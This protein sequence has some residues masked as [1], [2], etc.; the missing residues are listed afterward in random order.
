MSVGQP[1][2][3]NFLPPSLGYIFPFYLED[4]G[5]S[6]CG[7]N[8]NILAVPPGDVYRTT[9]FSVTAVKYT[10]NDH[11]KQLPPKEEAPMCIK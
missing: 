1:F 7:T 6:V 10:N 11:H 5:S 4:G 9:P 2:P 8:D 3:A